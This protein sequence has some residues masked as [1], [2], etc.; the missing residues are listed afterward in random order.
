LISIKLTVTGAPDRRLR[1]SH[2]ISGDYRGRKKEPRM[3]ADE[4]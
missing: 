2:P 4:R 3:N 1:L